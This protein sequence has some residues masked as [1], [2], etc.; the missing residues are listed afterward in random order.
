MAIF[1][2]SSVNSLYEHFW[3]EHEKEFVSK[4]WKRRMRKAFADRLA[5]DLTF[6]AR[7]NYLHCVTDKEIHPELP[8][9]LTQT[10]QDSLRQTA[11]F[12]LTR[13]L[14][15]L[16]LLPDPLTDKQR[17]RVKW[18]NE[19]RNRLF[20]NGT[21]H[22]DKG[23]PDSVAANANK[24]IVCLNLDIAR[25]GIA[26]FFDF[27]SFKLRSRMLEAKLFFKTGY[28]H[29]QDILR[30]SAPQFRARQEKEWS[31]GLR[32]PGPSHNTT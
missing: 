11:T 17:R 31:K 3:Q 13:Y 26:F 27:S 8:L 28:Y 30:E 2:M 29:G 12:K 24:N 9:D 25:F 19:V 32:G 14:E 1:A 16:R 21:F 22:K 7:T 15:S 6:R 10:F 4:S 18:L 20:H 5:K 23:M